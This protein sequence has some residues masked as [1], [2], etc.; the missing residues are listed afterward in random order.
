LAELRN[1]IRHSRAVSAVTQKEGEA[2]ILWF[3]QLLGVTT[4]V[5]VSRPYDQ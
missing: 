5:T 1:G 3:E 4:D 2:A